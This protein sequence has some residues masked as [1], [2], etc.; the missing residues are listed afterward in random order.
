[1]KSIQLIVG[2]EFDPDVLLAQLGMAASKTWR[3]GERRCD[4]QPITGSSG[5]VLQIDDD[6]SQTLAEQCHRAC[7]FLM[8][9]R[10]TILTIRAFPGVKTA[11]VQILMSV[12]FVRRIV[13]WSPGFSAELVRVAGE[14]GLSL[15]FVVEIALGPG[16]A[17]AGPSPQ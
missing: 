4:G 2:G 12:E 13:S 9:H 16:Y 11:E 17:P 8:T 10:N 1:M 3:R 6:G 5:F 14:C 7:Q 15:S